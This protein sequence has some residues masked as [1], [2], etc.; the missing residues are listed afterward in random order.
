MKA[1][2]EKSIEVFG[3]YIHRYK[4]DEAAQRENVLN[5]WY[6]EQIKQAV[7]DVLRKCENIV[8][9]QAEEW[10]I[11]ICVQNGEPVIL[12]RGASG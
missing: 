1:D 5:E 4:Y 8:G 3:T 10:Y 12:K 7:P 2:K 9:V 11:K 6:R